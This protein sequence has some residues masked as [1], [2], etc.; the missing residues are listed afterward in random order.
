MNLILTPVYRDFNVTTKMIEA[1]DKYSVMPFVHILV[2]DN[3]PPDI[4]LKPGPN[5]RIIYLYSDIEG[6][7]HKNQLGQ[8]LQIGYDYAHQKA[9]NGGDNAV[10][11]RTFII[12]SD[13]YVMQDWDARMVAM[14][15]QL[16]KDWATL[17]CMS[18]DENLKETYPDI[19]T[20]YK[21]FEDMDNMSLFPMAM[22][23]CTL[24]NPEIETL[25][26]WGDLKSH[27]DVLWSR[28]IEELTKRKFYRTRSLMVYHDKGGGN[29]RRFLP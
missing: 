1:I 10:L 9:F 13:V 5:R 18:V 28:K 16:P 2:V 29:S 7:P 26:K 22:F 15:E 23:Q 6:S 25:V 4:K 20:P 24:I 19:I 12:E 11:D 17:D 21:K 27:F 8:C 3:S 14:S